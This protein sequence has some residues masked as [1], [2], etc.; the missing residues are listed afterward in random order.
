[1]QASAGLRLPPARVAALL[2][3]V[4][5]GFGVLMGHVARTR[6]ADVPTAE[7]SALRLVVPASPPSGAQAASTQPSSETPAEQPANSEPETTPAPAAAPAKSTA[8]PTGSTKGGGGGGSGGSEG[9][10][11]AAGSAPVAGTPDTKLPPIKHVFVIMLSDEPYS[12]VFGPSSLAHYLE[13]TLVAKGELL[14]AYHAVAHEELADELALVSGQG[15]TAEIAA[16]CPRYT[17]LVSTGV[18]PDEAVLGSGCVYPSSTQTLPGELEA[19]H[20]KWRAYIQ[21]I[22]EAGAST[23]A[24]AHPELGASDPSAEQSA[25]TGAYATFRNPFV[26]LGSIVGSPSCAS[27]DVGLPDLKGDLA[28][29]KLTPSFS[30]IAPDRCHDGN[31]TPCTPGAP[32]GAGDVESFLEQVVPEITGSKAYKENGLLVITTDE[33][34]SS[35]PLAESSSCCGE[36][37]FPNDPAK[38]LTGAPG[39][40]GIVGALLLSPFVKAG[41]TSQEQYNDF[42]LLSTVEDL[43]SLR[44]IGYT[45]LPAV[46]AFEPE[47]FVSR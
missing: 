23:G 29:A 37:L 11:G 7:R 5:L 1:L 41:S 4:F 20:L 15:P 26:Y 34:P 10:S 18:G 32:A 17:E 21:G 47:M 2:V 14:P 38:T 19:K 22:D 31:P 27:D 9:G 46:K 24:C 25:S 13:G 16:N 45:A 12:S 36:P 44:H 39:G 35:G 43:F 33:A 42:S 8:K 3:V 6:S 28:N 40:G 30:Y